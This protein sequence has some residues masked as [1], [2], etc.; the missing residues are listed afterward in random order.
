MTPSSQLVAVATLLAVQVSS[1]QRPTPNELRLPK[2]MVSLIKQLQLPAEQ[3][4][5]IKKLELEDGTVVQEGLSIKKGLL[6]GMLDD[7]DAKARQR[8]AE[9]EH[10]VS[11]AEKSKADASIKAAAAT[12]DVARAELASSKA[13]RAQAQGGVSDQ[14]VRRQ[15]L[16]VTRADS[17][18][19]V[20]QKE[21]ET[22]GLTIEAKKAQLDVAGITVKHHRIESS[23]DGIIV[24]MFRRPGEWVNP[25]EPILRVLYMDK[26]R[27]E[28]FVDAD[29]YTPDE[30]HGKAVEVVANLPR[31]RVERFPAVITFVS[32]LVDASGEYRVWCEVENRQ[33]NGHWILRPGMIAEMTIKLNSQAA[34][35]AKK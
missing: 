4:G 10:R 20:A 26:L 1:D 22:A 3:A 5:V 9:A 8:A 14:E 6:L 29:Q 27:V 18:H 33:H 31:E 17:E 12:T 25:G 15:E 2:C 19:V 16:T 30:I 24:Q 28:G 21:A 23:L 7:E 32:P 35:V 11:L 13:I 34:K